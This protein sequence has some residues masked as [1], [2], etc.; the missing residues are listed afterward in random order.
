M[1]IRWTC[2][3]R[4][5][6]VRSEWRLW[7]CP[8]GYSS[9]RY[10]GR[11]LMHRE[12]RPS[13]SHSYRNRDMRQPQRSKRNLDLALMLTNNPHL[14]LRWE[15]SSEWCQTWQVYLRRSV[16]MSMEPLLKRQSPHKISSLAN[17]LDPIWTS[18]KNRQQRKKSWLIYSVRVTNNTSQRI[19]RKSNGISLKIRRLIR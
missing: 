4:I 18:H 3:R 11:V 9:K 7:G 15:V 1:S 10:R 17:R 6:R 8:K 13:S 5:A 19:R 12:C 2:R 14:Q 16:A